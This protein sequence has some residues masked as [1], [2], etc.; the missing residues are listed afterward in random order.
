M[1]IRVVGDQ[2]SRQ[3]KNRGIMKGVNKVILLG[4]VGAEPELRYTVQQHP[5]C[6]FPLATHRQARNAEGELE[7]KTD[8]HTIVLF[9]NK[10]EYFAN[11]LQKGSKIY[12][13][14]ILEYHDVPHPKY[15]DV[16]LHKCHIEAAWIEVIDGL[17]KHPYPDDFPPLKSAIGTSPLSSQS[18]TKEQQKEQVTTTKEPD[19]FDEQ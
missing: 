10:A 1:L 13:E 15:K 12:V 5:I 7:E 19:L 11:A 4:H 16:M 8:W 2:L 6:N 17:V 18:N 14:G 9:E 3:E